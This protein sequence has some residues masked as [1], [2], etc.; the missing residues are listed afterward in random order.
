MSYAQRVRP[1]VRARVPT[2]PTA[3]GVVLG[4]LL[5]LFAV[6]AYGQFRHGYLFWEAPVRTVLILAP[7][8]L[9][10]LVFAIL[11]GLFVP[12]RLAGLNAG[13][14]VA[15]VFGAWVGGVV[16]GGALRATAV[17]PGNS[18]LV[19]LLVQVAF[20]ALFLVPWRLAVH[21]RLA[22]GRTA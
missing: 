22:S 19:F 21:W 9:G 3:G 18:P 17:L 2:T 5:V 6:F 7:F 20:G 15:T 4:D 8:A 16:V 14:L 12:D 10:W 11:T 13:R 1:L